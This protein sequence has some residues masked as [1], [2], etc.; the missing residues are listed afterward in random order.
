MFKGIGFMI[1]IEMNLK[2]VD[3]LDL[4][5]NLINGIYK[6][7]KK[8]NDTFL[9][10]NRDLNHPPH[11]LKE[12]LKVPNDRFCRNSSNVYFMHWKVNMK[13]HQKNNGYKNVNLKFNKEN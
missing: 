1:D 6:P 4:T 5:F 10:I 9:Y 11:I 2:I 12:L 3:F 8:P 7:Y 13:T